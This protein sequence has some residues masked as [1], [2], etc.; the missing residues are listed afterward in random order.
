MESAPL[1][2]NWEFDTAKPNDYFTIT[3]Y[4]GDMPAA[5]LNL[6]TE[7]YLKVR[8]KGEISRLAFAFNGDKK[9]ISGTFKMLHKDLKVETLT[10]NGNK[11]VIVSAIANIFIKNDS[12]P[13]PPAIVIENVERDNTK[14]F[15]NFLWRGIEAGLK[16]TLVG[17]GSSA[18]KVETTEEFPDDKKEI[19]KLKELEQ[20]PLKKKKGFF[21][22][23]FQKKKAEK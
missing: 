4:T 17:L 16:K 23:L 21:K 9:T 6:F 8:A 1:T 2:V 19:Q 11:N 20:K 18:K 14:S 13:N 7:P 5:D 22:R 10:K 15:F 3:G 12:G